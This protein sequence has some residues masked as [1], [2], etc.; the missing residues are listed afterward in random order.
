MFV[1][2]DEQ[3]CLAVPVGDVTI[4]LDSWMAEQV[5][6]GYDYYKIVKLD[7]ETI[8]VIMEIEEKPTAIAGFGLATA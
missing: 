4:T 1:R 6:E 7:P 3:F 2:T 8:M 5:G